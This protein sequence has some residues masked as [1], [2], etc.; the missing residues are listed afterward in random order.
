MKRTKTRIAASLLTSAFAMAAGA[1]HL[2]WVG[3]D[4]FDRENGKNMLCTLDPKCRQLTTEE[5][6]VA[7]KYFGDRIDYKNVKIFDR[8]FVYMI[9]HNHSGVSPNGHINFASSENYRPNFARDAESA[10][11]FI[12]EMTHVAQYQG[13][14]NLPQQAFLTLLRHG[15]NYEAAYKYEIHTPRAYG[16]MNLEQQAKVMEDYFVKRSAF[17]SNTTIESTL[18]APPKPMRFT[19]FGPA[20]VKERC[21]EL[22]QYEFK[23]AAIYAIQPDELCRLPAP[24]MRLKIDESLFFKHP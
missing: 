4:Y 10:P 16:E 21:Q 14:M 11:L 8:P 20:W 17:E 2:D 9:G 22:K 12:H 18:D 24:H 13:G 1:L 3:Y 19:T 5:I 6:T 23:L 7:R 15:F